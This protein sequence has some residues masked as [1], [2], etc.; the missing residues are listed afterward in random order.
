MCFDKKYCSHVNK[1]F[2]LKDQHHCFDSILFSFQKHSF[3]FC[4]HENCCLNKFWNSSSY[5]DELLKNVIKKCLNKKQLSHFGPCSIK[6]YFPNWLSE[7]LASLQHFLCFFVNLRTGINW[8]QF[9]V[10]KTWRRT[11]YSF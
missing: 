8:K 2:F 4:K 7:K 11:D 6:Q 3:I 1:K 9:V 10:R 5:W